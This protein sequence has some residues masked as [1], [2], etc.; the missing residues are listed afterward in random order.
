MS[1]HKSTE[2]PAIHKSDEIFTTFN[3]IQDMI[4]ESAN[5]IFHDRNSDE[6][7]ALSDWLKAESEVLSDIDLTLADDEG[8][9][10]IQGD[11]Q[12]FLPEEI[13]VKAGDGMVEIGGIHTEKSSR[14]K[15]GVTRSTSKQ[16]NFYRSFRLP[17]SVDTDKMDVKL[18]NGKF[19]A[20]IP[21]TP[22]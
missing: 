19:T 17:D 12:G 4:R 6:G 3:H 9:V 5:R 13:E 22:H 1:A 21:K 16:I 20:R 8:Q 18:K 11:M 7:D 15:K 2:L 10:V 14:E